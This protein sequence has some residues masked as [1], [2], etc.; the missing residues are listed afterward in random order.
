MG[1]LV[2]EI[3]LRLPPS[4]PTSL[5]RAALV[6][7]PW[8]RLVSGRRLRRR[9]R[10]RHRRAPVL[11]LLCNSRRELCHCDEGDVFR[12]VP[13]ARF[14][15]GRAFHHNYRRAIDARHGRVLL[16]GMLWLDDGQLGP[17]EFTVWN[18]IT[19][20]ERTLPPLPCYEDWNAA[21]LCAAHATGACDHLD[22]HRGPFLV[23]VVDTELTG[24]IVVHIYSSEARS[25]SG[26][27]TVVPRPNKP[28]SWLWPSVLAGNS[29]YF[30]LRRRRSILKYDLGTLEISVIDDLPRTSCRPDVLTTTEDGRLGFATVSKSRLYLWTTKDGPA[31]GWAQSRVVDLQKLLPVDAH[32][33]VGFADGVGTVFV[34]TNS[35][36]Y[37]VDLKSQQARNVY[38][39]E[40]DGCNVLPY[41]TFYYPALGGDCTGEE[42][43]AGA[44]S[45]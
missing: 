23:V 39:P 30:M 21:V 45:A 5:V 3:L 32:S 44:S 10:E 1:E 8:F 33:V 16:R 15:G 14:P 28:A 19:G 17:G 43:S 7:K 26:G 27:Q 18:P 22:C 41:M 20:E 38:E 9:F 40:G 12:F 11:G 25:W 29:L 34:G 4:D 37:S 36:V 6:C 31:G 24:D 42:P 35:G 2:E 13:Y